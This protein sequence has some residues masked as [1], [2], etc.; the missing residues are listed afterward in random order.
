MIKGTQKNKKK[1]WW[2]GKSQDDVDDA[3]NPGESAPQ[4]VRVRTLPSW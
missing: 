3:G 1:Q 4:A 2:K